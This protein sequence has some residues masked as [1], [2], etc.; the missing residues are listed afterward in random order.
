MDEE[1]L[2]KLV[3]KHKY[4]FKL[5][6][7][8]LGI[9]EEQA[10]KNWTYLYCVHKKKTSPSAADKKYQRSVTQKTKNSIEVITAADLLTTVRKKIDFLDHSDVDFTLQ[11]SISV[12]GEEI[13]PSGYCVLKHS[14]KDTFQQMRNRVKEFLPDIEGD[15]IIADDD[16]E[17]NEFLDFKVGIENNQAVFQ[18][19]GEDYDWRSEVPPVPIPNFDDIHVIPEGD[20][21]KPKNLSKDKK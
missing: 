12:T 2:R 18:T 21:P 19:K 9:T 3:T 13:T 16:D 20:L 17:V 4:N 6:S 7:E 8:E 11:R 1:L 15:D 5:I 10:R 14:L